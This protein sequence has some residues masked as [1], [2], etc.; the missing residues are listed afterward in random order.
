MSY[1]RLRAWL[2]AGTLLMEACWVWPWALAL[3]YASGSA[4]PLLDLPWILVLLGA[5]TYGTRWI[6]GRADL[7][8]ARGAI[9]ACGAVLGFLSLHGTHFS[10]RPLTDW[11]WVAEL[12]DTVT[13]GRQGPAVPLGGGLGMYL[14]WRGIVLGTEPH[15][16]AF[17]GRR[18]VWGLVMLVLFAFVVVFAGRSD[19]VVWSLDRGGWALLA[20]WIVALLVLASARLVA[21]WEES[22]TAH[23]QALQL[24]RN[25]Y[26][27]LTGV[28]AAILVLSVAAGVLAAQDVGWLLRPV[29]AAAEWLLLRVLEVVFAILVPIVKLVHRV[30]SALPWRPRTLPQ[31]EAFSP[32]DEIAAWLRSLQ[33]QDATAVVALRWTAFL[34]VF[35]LLLAVMALYVLRRRTAAHGE[36][37]EE[38]ESVFS[39]EL[40][41]AELRSLFRRAPHPRDPEAPSGAVGA[42]RRAY[43]AFLLHMATVGYPRDPASTPTEYLASVH[44]FL[45]GGQSAARSL[46]DLYQRARYGEIADQADARRALEWLAMLIEQPD[47]ER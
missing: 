25:W 3:G 2:P 24:N 26:A 18:F 14:W 9:L 8:A 20:F 33:A 32:A 46:T 7:R 35:G 11:G 30:L 47:A 27:V 28:I 22:R 40:L 15:D 34:V 41:L 21:V 1:H 38:R 36:Q 37:T 39:G 43:R 42:V 4:R 17:V 44:T 13:L 10:H 45:A 5:S 16:F 31:R 23:A 19:V 6:L 29:G 12:L